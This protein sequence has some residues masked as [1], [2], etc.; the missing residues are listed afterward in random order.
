MKWKR[1]EEEEQTKRRNKNDQAMHQVNMLIW[2]EKIVRIIQQ[3]YQ[4]IIIIELFAFEIE[5]E[6]IEKYFQCLLI[7]LFFKISSNDFLS[8]LKVRRRILL[9]FLLYKT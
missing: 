8:E 3:Y 4:E 7:C 2:K 6:I 5:I 1:F 9:F